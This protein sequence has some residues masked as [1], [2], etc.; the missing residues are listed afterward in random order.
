VAQASYDQLDA[1]TPEQREAAAL[2]I[3]KIDRTKLSKLEAAAIEEHGREVLRSIARAKLESGRA[4]FKKKDYKTATA[5]LGKALALWPEHPEAVEASFYLGASAAEVK[6][7]PAVVSA[8]D[9]YVKAGKG[10]RGNRSYAVYLL[11]QGLAE[12]GDKERAGEVLRKGL[13]D[14]GDGEYVGPMRRVLSSMRRSDAPAT[15]AQ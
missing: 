4:A 8:M 10:S 6:E 5:D 15:A 2:A 14:Y 13:M 9:R 3:A 7:W 11:G 1:G 12:T